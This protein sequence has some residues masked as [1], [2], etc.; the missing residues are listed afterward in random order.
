MSTPY[1]RFSCDSTSRSCRLAMVSV[2]SFQL[3]ASW[4]STAVGSRVGRRER[5]RDRAF[6][7]EAIDVPD[8]A[9]DDE[10]GDDT[11]GDGHLPRPLLCQ[12]GDMASC[13]V[14]QQCRALLHGA[15]THVVGNK[16][17]SSR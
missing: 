6:V 7:A 10:C 12:V 17:E 11:D 15:H 5:A 13:I 1:H 3:V 2:L 9:S 16:M 8:A 14:S 4:S